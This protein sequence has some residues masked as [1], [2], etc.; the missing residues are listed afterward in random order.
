MSLELA[1]NSDFY[2]NHPYLTHKYAENIDHSKESIFGIA[3]T[4]KAA[5]SKDPVKT[6]A[7]HI[8]QNRKWGSLT[9]MFALSTIISRNIISVYPATSGLNSKV[10]NGTIEPRVNNGT[11]VENE[12]PDKIVIMWSRTSNNVSL[13]EGKYQAN[14]FVPLINKERVVDISSNPKNKET[15]KRKKTKAVKRKPIETIVINDEPPAPKLKKLQATNTRKYS[16]STNLLKA[17]K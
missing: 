17:L 7:D 16:L 12:S 3:F 10:L 14:H 11:N 8:S 1:I 4:H 5:N 9:A 15:T 13:D 6:E 2:K